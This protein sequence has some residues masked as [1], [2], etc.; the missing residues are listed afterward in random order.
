MRKRNPT[1]GSSPSGMVRL[2]CVI[3]GAAGL[4]LLPPQT[5]Q[6][7]P[8]VKRYIGLTAQ[9]QSL[10]LGAVS[11]PGLY[12]S[13]AVLSLHLAANCNHGRLVM[14]TTPLQSAGGDVIPPSRV[15]VRLPETGQYVPLTQPV[16][17]AP[18]AGPGVRD[19]QLRF[20]IKTQPTDPAGTYTATFNL[21]VEGVGGF[22]AVPGPAVTYQVE[23]ERHTAY[24]FTGTRTYIHIGNIFR[25]TEDELTAH[26][27]GSVSTNHGLYIGLN[28]AAV[29]GINPNSFERDSGGQL[30]GRIYDAMRGTVDVLGRSIA[31]EAFDLRVLLSWDGGGAYVAPTYYGQSPDGNVS[32]TLWW[33]LKN[34]DPGMYNLDFKIRLLPEPVQADGNYYFESEIVVTPA[35]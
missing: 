11:Q 16:V 31:N 20:R 9:P 7:L 18:G 4:L 8:R 28:L 6:A 2:A 32:K 17:I 24:E 22:P 25:A 14:T 21:V 27:V 35:L 5:S 33:L 19:F 3:A 26:T 34:G 13:P 10:D 1:R 12:D 30:T 29:S 23:L 15:F